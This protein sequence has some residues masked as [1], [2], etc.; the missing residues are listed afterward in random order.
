MT[1]LREELLPASSHPNLY[2]HQAG[3]VAGNMGSIR[4]GTSL[5]GGGDGTTQRLETLVAMTENLMAS[6]PGV[7]SPMLP[8]MASRPGVA[9]PMLPPIDLGPNTGAPIYQPSASLNM[10]ESAPS[11]PITEAR[12]ALRE[13]ARVVRSIV[14]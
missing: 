1:Q 4:V 5:G 12:K 13:S 14:E 2:G 9:S 7:A 8:P 11:D 6:R 10:A 3:Q